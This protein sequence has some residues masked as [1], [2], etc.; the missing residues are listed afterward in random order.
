M[1]QVPQDTERNTEKIEDSYRLNKVTVKHQR[2]CT[3]M[4]EPAQMEVNTQRGLDRP[5]GSFVQSANPYQD[6]SPT[7]SSQLNTAR[8][9]HHKN[10][11]LTSYDANIVP[12][13]IEPSDCG[14]SHANEANQVIDI[15]QENI[16]DL[17]ASPEVQ[18]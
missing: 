11:S 2:I 5:M 7:K 18:R 17:Q 3:N 1:K 10:V 4:T 15:P 13:K 8:R 12:A 6:E 9:P 16:E 14:L